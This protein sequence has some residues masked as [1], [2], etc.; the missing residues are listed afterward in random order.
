MTP[1]DPPEGYIENYI[2]L[3]ADR[4][5][6]NFA[7]LLDLKVRIHCYMAAAEM[8]LTFTIKGPQKGR[9]DASHRNFPTTGRG[10]AE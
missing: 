1:I 7:R 6:E 5:Q 3:I 2:F 9:S 8:H 10:N 4:N